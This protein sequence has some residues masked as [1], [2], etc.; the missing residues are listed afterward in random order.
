MDLGDKKHHFC[1]LNQSAEVEQEGTVTNSRAGLKR[2]FGGYEPCLIAIETGT[3]SNWV[4]NLLEELGHTV[5]VA[6]ARKLRAIYSNERKCDKLDAEMLARLARSDPKLLSPITHRGD[7]AQ[8]DLSI[9]RSRNNLVAARTQFINHVRGVVKSHGERVRQASAASFH[10]VAREALPGALRPALFPVL[11]IIEK[12]TEEIKAFDRDIE[13]LSKEKYP[14]TEVLRSVPGVGPITALC[15]VLTLE[16]PERF[17][18]SR[19]VPAYIGLVPERC[20]SGDSDPQMRIT[21][22]GSTHL[23]C[24]LVSSAQYIL[25]VHGPDSELRQWGER[26]MARGGTNA[27][28]RAVVA[29]A[30]KLSVILHRLWGSGMLYTPF[31]NAP[32]EDALNTPTETGSGRTAELT[33]APV[34]T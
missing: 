16:T 1:V 25:G 6:N 10:K 30:R 26:L 24:L 15:Y 27:R 31:P 34:A 23:R 3:H 21:K 8:I 9:I 13:R 17:K 5:L 18:T 22:C 14:E 32:E 19:N 2:V 29:V 7:D 11:D 28:K 33:A 20:Q 12:L 4:S